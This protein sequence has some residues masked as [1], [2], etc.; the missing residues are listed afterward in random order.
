MRE[1]CNQFLLKRGIVYPIWIAEER[2][3]NAE[4][5]PKVKYKFNN[6]WSIQKYVYTFSTHFSTPRHTVFNPKISKNILNHHMQTCKFRE[7]IDLKNAQPVE[8]RPSIP[9]LL[10]KNTKKIA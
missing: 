4:D 5:E 8:L 2:Q 7:A 3:E 9:P 10:D 1:L 6:K